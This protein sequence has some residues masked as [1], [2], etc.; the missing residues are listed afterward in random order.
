[1]D[2]WTRIRRDILVEN[3]S[4]RGIFQKSLRYSAD[5][6][7]RKLAV[8]MAHDNGE[9]EPVTDAEFLPHFVGGWAGNIA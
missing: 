9:A 8:T 6:W 5:A 7:N 4:R 3:L 2:K 1:M